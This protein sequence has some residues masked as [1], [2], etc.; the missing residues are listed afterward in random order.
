MNKRNLFSGVLF[1]LLLS[2]FFSL[3]G[4]RDEDQPTFEM[5]GQQLSA[6][7]V[8]ETAGTR[9]T[10]GDD[11]TNRKVDVLWHP[12]DA[13]GVFGN[14]GGSNVRFTT[15]GVAISQDGRTTV[16]ETTETI[17]QATLL[18][19]ILFNRMLQ[20]LQAEGFSLPCRPHRAMAPAR[21]VLCDLIPGRT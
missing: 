8:E 11:P 20:R 4:C 19:I 18:P 21:A 6:T 3:P 5:S 1:S 12:G 14:T 7:I 17:Q 16:F 10:L 15:D 13:I 9:T 2:L